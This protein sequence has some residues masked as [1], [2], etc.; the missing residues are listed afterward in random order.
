MDP[1]DNAVVISVDEKPGMHAL[2]RPTSYVKTSS[3]KIVKGL[4]STYRRNGTLNLFAALN[5]ITGKV[6]KG[7]KGSQFRISIPRNFATKVGIG[8]LDF[9]LLVC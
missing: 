7:S 6:C 4:K 9:L 1:P 8:K 5:V 2:E 3:T